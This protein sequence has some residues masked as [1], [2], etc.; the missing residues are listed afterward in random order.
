M[1][2]L[3]GED[4]VVVRVIKFILLP[5]ITIRAPILIQLT[6]E[7]IMRIFGLRNHKVGINLYIDFFKRFITII[8]INTIR[9]Y[10]KK[11]C[12]LFGINLIEIFVD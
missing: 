6:C 12:S 7:F 3:R 11:S 10:R 2:L 5:K 1:Y 8:V 4:Y 9:L